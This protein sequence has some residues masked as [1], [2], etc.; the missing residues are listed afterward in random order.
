ME[1]DKLCIL[2]EELLEIKECADALEYIAK[3]LLVTYREH[4]CKEGICLS[5][6]QAVKKSYR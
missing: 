3:W 6:Q 1:K 5:F 2:M 4:K